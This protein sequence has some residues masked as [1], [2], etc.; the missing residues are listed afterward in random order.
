[1]RKRRKKPIFSKKK[2][3]FRFKKRFY[4][5]LLVVILAVV[6]LVFALTGNDDGKPKPPP[7]G[8]PVSLNVLCAGDLVI[9]M[10]VINAAKKSDGTYNFEW[11]FDSVKSYIG[12]AD[13][14]L[15]NLE[16][17]FTGGN[18]S[19]YPIFRCPDELAT[20]LAAVGFDLITTSS[21]HTFDTGEDGMYR[22]IQVLD[23]A[24][25]KVAGSRPDTET[26]R[27]TMVEKKGVKI[28]VVSYAYGGNQGGTKD[29]NGNVLTQNAVDSINVFSYE[30]FDEDFKEIKAT[31]TAAKEAGADIVIMYYHWG[32]EY[33]TKSNETQQ[34]IAQKTVDETE[35]DII[36][37]S[38][39]HVV[40]EK[41]ILTKKDSKKEVPVYYALGNLLSNQR[42]HLVYD[43]QHVE[44]GVMVNF[45]ITYDPEKKKIT[46]LK[47]TAIPYWVDKYE[48]NGIKY[49]LIPLVEGYENS[50]ILAKSGN[51]QLATNALSNVNSILKG[52]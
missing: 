31:I 44:E 46:S 28:A 24:G 30:T 34:K 27:Y 6:G 17:T 48:D 18:Y 35:V 12:D 11:P 22:T 23:K 16:T 1:M 51:T 5:I 40:Q 7:P 33:N 36:Y 29:L 43:N 21:N 41:A 10:D 45:E 49:Q 8:D 4:L 19:G 37:G 14:A 9:H 15:C 13:L 2:S 39:P 32:D 38:H 47:D 3:S 52:E 20:S 25:L 42:R 26:P 50:P